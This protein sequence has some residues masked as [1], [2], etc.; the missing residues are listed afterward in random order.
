MHLNG[1]A[2]LKSEMEEKLE[3]L[4]KLEEGLDMPKLQ[5]ENKLGLCADH[6]ARKQTMKERIHEPKDEIKKKERQA[7]AKVSKWTKLQQENEEKR[8]AKAEKDAEKLKQLEEER[9]AQLE[10]KKEEEKQKKQEEFDKL[11]EEIKQ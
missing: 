7:K 3:M 8:K 10:Q 11:Q 5:I 2:L 9:K 4:N 6:D 1:N